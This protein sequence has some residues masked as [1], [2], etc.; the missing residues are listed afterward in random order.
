MHRAGFT[1]VAGILTGGFLLL[2]LSVS[3]ASAGMSQDLADCT[4]AKGRSAA[5]A[6]TRVMKSGR[7]SDD[8]M[9]I[10]YFNRGTAYLRAGDA[11]KA[12]DDF[13]KVIDLKPGFARGYGARAQAEEDLG[14]RDRALDDLRRAI[15]RDRKQW[16]FRYDRALLLRADADTAGALD[17]LDA[18]AEL[19]P[20]AKH[21][22]LMRVIVLAEKGSY[23][24]ARREIDAIFKS[25][26]PDIA[27]YYARALLAFEEGHTSEAEADA[28]RALKDNDDFGAA[29]LLKGRI[30]E[31]RNSGKAA[32]AAFRKA[33]AGSYEAFDARAARRSA[34]DRLAASDGSKTSSKG[35]KRK[36]D[37]AQASLK[38]RPLDCKVFLPATGTVVSAKCNE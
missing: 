16:R 26:A 25:G 12:R 24:D 29:H 21:V 34:E 4:A 38:E 35:G 20:D 10:G 13:S 28:D 2:V 18:A 6:C 9:Y 5:T 15:E 36:G 19:D 1:F 14:N 30:F 37:V 22:P 3:G 27:A 8:Q 11:A 17:D 23:S 31:R 7:L 33:L 32:R